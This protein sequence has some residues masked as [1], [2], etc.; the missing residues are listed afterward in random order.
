[1]LYPPWWVSQN[2]R[3]VAEQERPQ[4]AGFPPVDV[5]LSRIEAIMRFDRR[6]QLARIVTPTLV[7]VAVDDAVTPLYFSQA[8]AKAIPG[9]KLKVFESGGHLL[10]HVIDR[11]YTRAVIDFLSSDPA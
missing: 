1:V 6:D 4:A 8:L 2:E 9:A 11:D 5:V 10:Y 3:L 7:S